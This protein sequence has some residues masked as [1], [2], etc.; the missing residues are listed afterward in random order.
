MSGLRAPSPMDGPSMKPRDKQMMPAAAATVWLIAALIAL[1]HLVR[2]IFV[3]ADGWREQ[4]FFVLCALY[5]LYVPENPVSLFSHMLIHDSWLHLGL[6]LLIFVI[7]GLR[8]APNLGAAAPLKVL[9]LTLVSGLSG[10]AA[11]ILAAPDSEVGVIGFSGAASGIAAAFL[12]RA[13]FQTGAPW[14]RRLAIRAA[15]V[16]AGLL[17]GLAIEIVWRPDGQGIAWEAHLGGMAGGAALYALMSL[18][19]KPTHTAMS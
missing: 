19:A 14:S 17:I 10:A 8:I 2:L 1:A 11:V 18:A 6:N 9:A 13:L 7:A 3:P 5:P 15:I 4:E 16:L 12:I